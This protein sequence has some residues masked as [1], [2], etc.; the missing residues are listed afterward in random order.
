[1]KFISY[2]L[3]ALFLL[4]NS[5]SAQN[6]AN[7]SFDKN[8]KKAELTYKV[9]SQ[10][11]NTNQNSELTL[12]NIQAT[13]KSSGLAMI[14]SLVLPGAGHYYIDRMDVGKY[15]AAGEAA[16]WLGFA[17]L[18]IYGDAIRNDSRTYAFEVAGANK[19]SDDEYYTNVGF[20]MNINDYNNDKLARGEY[21]KL[22]DVNKMS[23]Y[24]NTAQE[25]G[26]FETQRKKSE[27]VLNARVIFTTA[28]IVNRITSAISALIL[29]NQQNTLLRNTQ[30]KSELIKGANNTYDGLSLNFIKYF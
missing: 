23:W 28:L 1:M 29:A 3:A 12:T 24:W 14:M 6:S 5:A 16:S 18:N 10:E 17:G 19:T 8:D 21:D 26:T 11:Q 4:L 27:R 30:I 7:F 2:V 25:Q 22:Y 9:L 15:F 20:Y 13:E